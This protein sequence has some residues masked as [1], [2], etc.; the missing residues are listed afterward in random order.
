MLYLGQRGL[1]RVP[2]DLFFTLGDDSLMFALDS[3]MG[4]MELLKS[5]LIV[6]ALVEPILDFLAKSLASAGQLVP[7]IFDL[8]GMVSVAV[9]E[10][11]SQ[12]L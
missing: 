6:L 4:G 8:T 9:S 1:R 7:E 11:A 12:A 10:L 5:G 3:V 2:F